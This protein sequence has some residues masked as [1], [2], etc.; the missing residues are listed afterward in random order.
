MRKQP[1][2]R[3]G[4]AGGEEEDEGYS[5]LGDGA[6]NGGQD[7]DEEDDEDN[8]DPED[9]DPEDEDEDG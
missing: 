5:D 7:S 3:G 1:Q 2:L 6:E 8:E 4:V 9:E